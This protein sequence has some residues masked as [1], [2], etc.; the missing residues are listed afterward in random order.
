MEPDFTKIQDE[1]VGYHIGAN[2]IN[3]P[4]WL[5]KLTFGQFIQPY[6]HRTETPQQVYDNLERELVSATKQQDSV[7]SGKRFLMMNVLATATLQREAM[8]NSRDLIREHYL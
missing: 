7:T 2:S 5:E 6:A 8:I 1:R 3:G 4:K